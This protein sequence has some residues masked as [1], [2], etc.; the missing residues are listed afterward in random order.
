ARTK[1][2]P[3]GE[4][5]EGRTGAWNALVGVPLLVGT[6]AICFG[7]AGAPSTSASTIAACSWST[8]RR[9]SGARRFCSGRAR[10]ARRAGLSRDRLDD[11]DP[12]GRNDPALDRDGRDGAQRNG[13]RAGA[14]PRG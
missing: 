10:S 5:R 11:G 13:S 3:R 8:A 14:P 9:S 1:R 4:Q 6:I 12:G 7:E 2:A